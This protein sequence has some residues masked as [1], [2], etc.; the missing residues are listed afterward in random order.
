MPISLKVVI[1]FFLLSLAFDGYTAVSGEATTVT[2]IR[3]AVGVGIIV[4]LLRGSESVRAIVRAFAV[5]GMLAGAV[6]VIRIVPYIDTA[7]SSLVVL[8]LAAACFALFAAMLTF[9]VL[10]REDVEMWMARRS[11]GP[12]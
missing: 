10:G 2:W 11:F 3:L 5:L 7:P 6:N 8:G 4:G 9:W 1:G 12:V